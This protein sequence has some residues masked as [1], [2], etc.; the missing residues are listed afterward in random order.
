MLTP[1]LQQHMC[2]HTASHTRSMQADNKYYVNNCV[3]S[4][5]RCADLKTVMWSLCH[6]V[7]YTFAKHRLNEHNYIGSHINSD[8]SIRVL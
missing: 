6:A 5:T 8:C 2:S 1:I 4:N 3:V 7:L